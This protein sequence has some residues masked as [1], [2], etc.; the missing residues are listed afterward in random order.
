[1]EDFIFCAVTQKHV[2]L[3]NFESSSNKKPFFD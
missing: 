3:R 1:M 2:S